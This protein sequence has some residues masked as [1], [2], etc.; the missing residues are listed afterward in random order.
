MNGL[1]NSPETKKYQPIVFVN[2][3][4]TNS[5]EDVIGFESQVETIQCAIDKGA[6]MIGI[7]ADYGSGKS[8]MAEM[9]SLS[10]KNKGNPRPIKINMWDCLSNINENNKISENVSTLTKSFLY[11]LSNGHNAKLGKYVNKVLSKNYGSIALAINDSKRFW[12]WFIIAGICY[13][14]YQ[15]ANIS[16]TGIMQYLPQCCDVIASGLKL[17]AP[18]FAFVAMITI[19][20]GMKDAYIAFSHWNMSNRREPEIND[21]FDIY[22]IIIEKIQPEDGKK[23]LILIDDL[24]RIDKKKLIV[25]FLKELYRFQDSLGANKNNFVFIISIKPESELTKD[26]KDNEAEVYSKIF[27]LTFSLK[28]IHFDDYDSILLKLLK[29]NPE[30][31]ENLEKLIEQ[32]IQDVLPESFRW[33]KRGT[34]L[35]LRD[36]KD[37]LNQAISIMISLKNKNY[38]VKTAVTFEPCAAVSYLEN[39]Y[40]KIIT[41][42]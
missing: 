16:G 39:K 24:D 4:I 28:P 38:K 23:Q 31:K 26:E 3:P 25:E 42:L 5:A 35:T 6:N 21:V 37:R 8:S 40:Q 27:D 10:E 30:Q 41:L 2:N 32:E 15:I 1:S 22:N 20:L 14:I 7:I 29:I 36:L 33:I 18:I 11:Q 9:L 19:I 34:N 12:S 17:S 13:T